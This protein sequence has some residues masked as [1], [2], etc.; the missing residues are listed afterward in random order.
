MR[1]AHF[2]TEDQGFEMA[3]AA[4][5][6]TCIVQVGSQRP[7]SV[8]YAKARQVFDSGS[9]SQVTAVEAWIDRNDSSGAW[10]YPI[11][12]DAY[13]KTI[14]WWEARRSD[15]SRLNACSAG[16]ATRTTAKAFPETSSSTCSVGFTAPP[17]STGRPCARFP[18]GDCSGGMMVGTC[19]SSSDRSLNIRSSVWGWDAI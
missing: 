15:P 17:G 9:L 12:P 8:A 4:E 19:R 11:P 5:K 2:P 10:V 13:E 14:N 16:A 7:S 18:Q 1:K 6:C 3:G